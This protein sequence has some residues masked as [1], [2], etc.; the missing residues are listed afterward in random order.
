MLMK[1][2]KMY[3]IIFLLFLNPFFI[4]AQDKIHKSDS[5]IIEARVLEINDNEIKYKKFNNPNGPSYI[6]DK[7]KVNMI[8]YENGEKDI[9]NQ[10]KAANLIKVEPPKLPQGISINDSIKQQKPSNYSGNVQKGTIKIFTELKGVNI[11]LDDKFKGT[12]ITLIDS[13]SIGSHYLKIM[14]DNAS[15]YNELVMV[16]ANETN[17]I[18]V[19]NNQ[20]VQNKILVSKQDEI[21]KYKM[22]RLDVMVSTSYVT[23]TNSNS[24]SAYYPGF[25][26]TTYGETKT[27]IVSNTVPVTDWFITQG[28]NTKISQLTFAKIT[29][30]QIYFNRVQAEKE[31]VEKFNKNRWKKVVPCILGGIG[32][33]VIGVA[34]HPQVNWDSDKTMEWGQFGE[35]CLYT[36]GGIAVI[37]GLAL[38][39]KGTFREPYISIDE[40]RTNAYIFNQKLKKSLG[41]PDSYEPTE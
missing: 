17:T 27:N 31:R 9:F 6:I 18:L 35:I 7:S 12:D 4:K 19:K 14:K 40:V 25:F 8:V 2:G 11:Y 1:Y 5:T 28:V 16:K 41:L 39:K 20:E 29:D 10:S 32:L 23:Q 24:K 34:V 22:G 26:S 37:A 15:I 21:Q 38:T 30:Y 33:I 13:V 3:C 36:Y